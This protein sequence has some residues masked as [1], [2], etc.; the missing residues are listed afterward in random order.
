MGY[1]YQ[2]CSR[3]LSKWKS[4]FLYVGDRLTLL[5]SVLGATPIYY[6][7]MYKAPMKRLGLLK[8]KGGMGVSSFFALNRALIFKWI[9]V[10]ILKAFL[11]GIVIL[12]A[13]KYSMVSM[14]TLRTKV[15]NGEKN[16]CSGYEYEG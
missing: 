8:D 11:F 2:Q 9:G 4:R 1:C 5:K 12:K 6:M 13:I 14:A 3:K 16:L 10:F 7:S 15:G